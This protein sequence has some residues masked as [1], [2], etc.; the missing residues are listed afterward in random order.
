M[1]IKNKK[2][3]NRVKW[4]LDRENLRFTLTSCELAGLYF[5]YT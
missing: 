2:A 5:L 4:T 1:A 3:K